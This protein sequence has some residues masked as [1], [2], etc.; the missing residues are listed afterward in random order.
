MK[1]SRLAGIVAGGLLLGSGA[2]WAHHSFSAEFDAEKPVTLTGIVTKVEWTNPH[3][4]FYINVKDEESGDVANWGAE[5]GPPHGLQ[6]R[7][8]RRDS[9]KIGEEVTVEGFLARNG[10]NRLNARAVTLT[11]TGGRPGETLDANSSRRGSD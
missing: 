9:L 4:W 1:K 8:W 10:S 11:A 3:V 5:M 6:R 2:A 7:G